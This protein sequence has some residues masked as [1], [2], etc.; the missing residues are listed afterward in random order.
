MSVCNI[1]DK[2][3]PREWKLKVMRLNDPAVNIICVYAPVS[4]GKWYF[5][6]VGTLSPASLVVVNTDANEAFVPLI[7]T[8]MERR[9]RTVIVTEDE[10]F[11]VHH[12][13]GQ[14]NVL[15]KY[16]LSLGFISRFGQFIVLSD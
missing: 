9:G 15:E 13:K 8:L 5:K 6:S 7:D 16:L 14:F 1:E 12:V 10:Q 11:V 3:H 2:L 4:A